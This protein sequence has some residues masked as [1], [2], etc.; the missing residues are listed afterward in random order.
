LPS[1]FDKVYWMRLAIGVVAGVGAKYI[2]G[3]DYLDGLLLGIIGYLMSYYAARY[4][5]FRKLDKTKLGKIYTT[6]I[7]GYVMVF[8][9]SWIL[10][11]T[12]ASPGF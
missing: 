9:F 4:V 3:A 7:G 1:E 6:G 5:W 10:L 2:F 12:L 8:L 11:F